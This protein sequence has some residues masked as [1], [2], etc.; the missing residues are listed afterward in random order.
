MPIFLL[1]V[2]NWL[3]KACLWL[4]KYWMWV[5]FPI[6]IVI[7]FLGRWTKPKDP[8]VIAPELLGA[9]D[10]K[11][12]EDEKAKRAEEEAKAELEKK[13]DQILEEHHK[14]IESLSEEQQDKVDDLLGDPE[15]L[16]DYLKDVGR[17]IRGD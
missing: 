10:K 14:L 8:T 5:V 2:W 17:S 13:R 15:A 16:N 4:K 3:K 1:G 9:A 6:G 11:L 12:E 7:F